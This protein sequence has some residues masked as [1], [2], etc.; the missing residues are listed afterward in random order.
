MKRKK[1]SGIKFM[2][3]CSLRGNGWQ[4][5]KINDCNMLSRKR[6]GEEEGD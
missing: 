6:T 3:F 2:L 5:R 1:N 4:R